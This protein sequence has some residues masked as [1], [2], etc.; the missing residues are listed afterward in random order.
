MPTSISRGNYYIWIGRPY[1]HQRAT[2]CTW[3]MLAR[4]ILSSNI[5]VTPSW[6]LKIKFGQWINSSY[7]RNV[8]AT[9]V[10]HYDFFWRR[11]NA[12]NI[13]Y[14][15]I[16]HIQLSSS[17]RDDSRM[18]TSSYGNIF[19]VTGPLYGEFTGHRWIPLTKPSDAELWCFLWSAPEQTAD[20]TMEKIWDVIAF[21][22]T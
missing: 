9:L 3:H 15:W 7:F 2:Q 13:R 19:R 11:C 10:L 20:Q 16:W 18:M 17:S 4:R 6:E 1:W 21:I 22:I 5:F 12:Q 8:S 14:N